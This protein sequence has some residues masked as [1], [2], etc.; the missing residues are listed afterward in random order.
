[1]KNLYKSL[2]AFQQE[3]PVIHEG[4]TGYGYKYADFPSILKVINP[5][6]QKHGLGFTQLVDNETLTTVLFHSESGE[7]LQSSVH[8]KQG[9]TLAKMNEYQVIGSAITY[10]RRYSL[11]AILGLVTDTDTDTN[12][13]TLEGEYS[14]I[15]IA[16]IGRM[17]K[18]KE[19]KDL[20]D[21]ALGLRN[22]KDFL[23][24]LRERYKELKNG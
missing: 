10:F 21:L 24:C 9:V 18:E 11:S 15:A 13:S 8:I 6:L 19:L 16:L 22:N 4:S 2:A 23:E 20:H 7:S 1:M 17:T 14:R 3:V 12:T 5:L